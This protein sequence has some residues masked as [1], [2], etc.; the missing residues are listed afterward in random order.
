MSNSNI[1]NQIANE[2]DKAHTRVV[3]DGELDENGETEKWASLV[4]IS[5]NNRHKDSG[6]NGI[7]KFLQE[8]TVHESGG[9]SILTV[10]YRGVPF[11][12]PRSTQKTET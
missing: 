10:K 9:I 4:G 3:E 11:K 7:G 6:N 2:F 8:N 1:F 12:F 5:N